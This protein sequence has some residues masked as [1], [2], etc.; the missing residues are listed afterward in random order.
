MISLKLAKKKRKER[1]VAR[2]RQS[3]LKKTIQKVTGTGVQEDS[4]KKLLPKILGWAKPPTSSMNAE[5]GGGW[6][7]G[8]EALLLRESPSEYVQ[9]ED[10][11]QGSGRNPDKK[12][13]NRI[14]NL[15][16]KRSLPMW[17]DL[18]HRTPTRPHYLSQ[19]TKF[20]LKRRK[21]NGMSGGTC[22]NSDC[23][24]E[25]GRWNR[26]DPRRVAFP[27]K[28]KKKKKRVLKKKETK[29]VQV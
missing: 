15:K 22:L 2:P 19:Q 5:G 10:T 13:K 6:E 1:E 7:A 17:A 28:K 25:K 11:E 12:E 14:T 21:K 27:A 9:K 20:L 3:R 8:H 4:K 18:L 24:K 16:G 23:K 26:G 29:K